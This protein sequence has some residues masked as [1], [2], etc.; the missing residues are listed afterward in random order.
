LGDELYGRRN[1]K[2]HFTG[3]A[4]HAKILGFDH[5]STNR[6]MEFNSDLPEY[7]EMLLEDLRKNYRL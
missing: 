1:R 6:Y 2:C 7:F 5:P 4:L 3:Q